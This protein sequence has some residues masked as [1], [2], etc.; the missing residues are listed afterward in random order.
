M[1]VIR[2]YLNYHQISKLTDLDETVLCFAF[3]GDYVRDGTNFAEWNQWMSDH[4]LITSPKG[5]ILPLIPARGNHEATGPLYDEVFCEAGEPDQNWYVMQIGPRIGLV[6]LNS[7]IS[8]EGEQLAFIRG[9]LPELRA[10]SRWLVAQYHIPLYPSVKYK[11]APPFKMRWIEEFDKVNL[12][13]AVESD[14]HTLKRTYLMRA[15]KKDPTGTL[16]I[17]DGGYGAPPR[18]PRPQDYHA[19]TKYEKAFYFIVEFNKDQLNYNCVTID[20]TIVDMFS[21]KPKTK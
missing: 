5:R 20:G 6:T 1:N 7:Q 11:G 18:K 17:G 9:A 4:E 10:K 8:E 19:F 16:Y 3:G 12:D 2:M 21:V 13:L 15:D 14:G